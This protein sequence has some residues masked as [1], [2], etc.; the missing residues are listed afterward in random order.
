MV[1]VKRRDRVTTCYRPFTS[2]IHVLP[3]GGGREGAGQSHL[4]SILRRFSL[5]FV[6]FCVTPCFQPLCGRKFKPCRESC[7]AKTK[8]GMPNPTKNLSKNATFGLREQVL[9]TK[10]DA[11]ALGEG[12]FFLRVWRFRLKT[13][14]R[15][16]QDLF[17]E[18]MYGNPKHLFDWKIYFAVSWWN[19]TVSVNTK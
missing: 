8:H 18:L 9:Y 3:N 12:F 11:I 6:T 7:D 15:I 14:Q 5:L 10:L 1:W 17:V 13:N 16:F 2:P 4:N 19:T